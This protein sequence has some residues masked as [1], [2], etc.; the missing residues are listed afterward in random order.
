MVFT[1]QNSQRHDEQIAMLMV[2]EEQ[3]ARARR[4]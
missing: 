4:A 2:R 1:L 3:M